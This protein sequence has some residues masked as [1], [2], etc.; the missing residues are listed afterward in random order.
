EY[1]HL[2][3]P[4]ARRIA[5]LMNSSN[6][7]APSDLDAVQKAAQ[8]LGLQ[9]ARFDVGNVAELDAALH[10][11]PKRGVSA[12]LI[13]SDALGDS[14][15]GKIA[16]SMRKAKLPAISPYGDYGTDGILI[17]YGVNTKEAG[18]KM[19][20]YVDKLLKGAKPAD[21]PIEEISTYKLLVDLRVAR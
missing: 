13:G 20:L 18:R 2:L 14:N 15:I 7:A 10:A 11:I 6:P 16:G 3:V 5:Y 9:I 12:V 1:L 8:K 21:L 19:A 4:R 17:S